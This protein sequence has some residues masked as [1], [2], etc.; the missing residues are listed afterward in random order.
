MGNHVLVCNSRD[1]DFYVPTCNMLVRKTACAQAGGLEESLRVGEDVDLCWKLRKLGHRLVYVP[2]G[3]VRHKHRNRF[4]PAMKRRYDYGTSEP[5][6]YDRHREV[7]K[8]FP[9]RPS[10]LLFLGSCC[11][12]LVARPLFF[13]LLA[14]G[15]AVATAFRNRA[16]VGKKTDVPLPLFDIMGATLKNFEATGY[17]LS[18]HF[19]RYYLLLAVPLMM[20]FP[21]AAPLWAALV[22]FPV[23]V[24]YFKVSPRLCFPVFVLYFAAEQVF[25]QTGVFAM[26]C[27]MRSFRCYR[28]SFTRRKELDRSVA[29]GRVSAAL[30]LPSCLSVFRRQHP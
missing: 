11:A 9:C 12:G 7:K 8:R 14:I 16:A 21:A 2:E 17:Y 19:V 18:L 26:C 29:P 30:R 5:I 23:T 1:S 3:A 28:L 15:V 20:V 4:W 10:A 6:L 13:S 27:G 22:L 24:E 25:Y